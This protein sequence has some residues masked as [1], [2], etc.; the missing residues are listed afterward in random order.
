ME[1]AKGLACGKPP[2]DRG[3][4]GL[5]MGAFRGVADLLGALRRQRGEFDDVIPVSLKGVAFDGHLG[6]VRLRHLAPGFV[7]PVIDNC[8]DRQAG[9]SRGVGDVLHPGGR[10]A[11]A[12]ECAS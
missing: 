10:S 8:L 3:L 9:R 2:T 12:V 7:R 1:H 11:P 4:D 6:E 5:D